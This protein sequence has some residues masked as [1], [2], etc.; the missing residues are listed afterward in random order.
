[1]DITVDVRFPIPLVRVDCIYI[2]SW[3]VLVMTASLRET[4]VQSLGP[5]V[6]EWWCK[7]GLTT[8]STVFSHHDGGSSLRLWFVE[9][10][11]VFR[12]RRGYPRRLFRLFSL[13]RG[14]VDHEG[15]A[16]STMRLNN[17]HDSDISLPR[18]QPYHLLAHLRRMLIGELKV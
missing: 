2:N 4:W 7:S 6:W 13:L 18:P 12:P 5:V 11:I 10:M 1:M 3:L 9:S 17:T 14:L 16:W 15:E 8:F